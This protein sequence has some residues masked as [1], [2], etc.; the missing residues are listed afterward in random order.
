MLSS[1]TPSVSVV[2]PTYNRLIELTRCLNSLVDQSYKNFDVLI[3]DDGSTENVLELVSSFNR[4]LKIYFNTGKNFGGPSVGRNRGILNSNSCIIAF[5]DSDDWW[6]PDMLKKSIE[7]ILNGADMTFSNGLSF[8]PSNN[9]FKPLRTI[10]FKNKN[11]FNSLFT[12]GNFIITSSVFIKRDCFKN[13]GLFS[14]NPNLIAWEDYDM[15]LRIARCGYTIKHINQNLVY[16][17]LSSDSLSLIRH[18]KIKDNISRILYNENRSKIL[19]LND[20][21]PPWFFYESGI[22]FYLK[23]NLCIAS[24]YFLK[25]FM[26]SIYFFNRRFILKSFFYLL[27]ILIKLFKSFTIKFN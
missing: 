6:H 3:C 12:D 10:S 5:L 13:L 17:S 14:E 4:K 16:Y 11:I 2:I 8:N 1:N 24:K 7:Y 25:V 23:N 27:L 9:S 26:Q 20:K 15:W 21:R 22:Y 19:C 18:Q